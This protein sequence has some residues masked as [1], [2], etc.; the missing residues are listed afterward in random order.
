[1]SA[2]TDPFLQQ[3]FAR[4]PL[5]LQQRRE[6]LASF[7]F[8]REAEKDLSALSEYVSVYTASPGTTVF[9]EGDTNSFMCLIIDGQLSIAKGTGTDWQTAIS[10]LN[11]GET[12]GEMALIDGLPRS[13][14]ALAL[15]DTTL[16]V[17]TRVNFF[18][19]ADDNPL[20]FQWLVT[21]IARRI[22]HRLRQVNEIL[23][24]S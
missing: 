6:K 7:P 8:T 15:T 3:G 5:T 17:I 21:K 4:L 11:P 12:V 18:R 22:S 23:A 1:M 20:L 10:V 9:R 14:T 13:A 24:H 2:A 16:F 19:M